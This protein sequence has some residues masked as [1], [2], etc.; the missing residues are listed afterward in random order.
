VEKY[1]KAR[2]QEAAIE[3]PYTHDLVSLLNLTLAVEPL[4]IAHAT[5]ANRLTQHA[6]KTRY[7]GSWVTRAQAKDTFMRCREIRMSVRESL[8]LKNK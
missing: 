1:L 2:L 3:I 6:V 5:S 8:G 4:W 7:P